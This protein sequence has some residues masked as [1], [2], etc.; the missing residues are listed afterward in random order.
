MIWQ[1]LAVAVGLGVLVPSADRFVDGAAALARIAGMPPLL[2]GMLVIGFGTSTP[3]L[4]VSATS[5]MDGESGL[6]LGNA[7]GS[8]IANIGLILGVSALFR[9]LPMHRRLVFGELSVLVIVTLWCFFWL[10][11][12]TVSRD[13]GVVMLVLF[14]ALIALAVFFAL[15]DKRGGNPGSGVE[16]HQESLPRAV[17]ATLIGLAFLI[18]AAKAIVW[19]AVG[20]ATGFGVSDLV[21]GLTV[22]AIGTSLPELASTLSAVRKNRV[23]MAF[24]NAIGSNLFNTLPVVGIS[25]VIRP[26]SVDPVVLGRDLPVMTACTVFLFLLGLRGCGRN[27]ELGPLQGVFL[28]AGFFVYTGYLLTTLHQEFP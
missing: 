15:R 17:L 14:A 6:A 2:I 1:I 20:I 26:F 23:D 11:D 10:H 13:D 24:G 3:E 21:I 4:L 16:G 28:C 12:K 27:T 7:Y 22:V 9:P 5:A 18:V 25:A 8:N 19:G